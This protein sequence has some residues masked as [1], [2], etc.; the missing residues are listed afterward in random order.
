[1]QELLFLSSFAVAFSICAFLLPSYIR[2][3]RQ[4][5]IV[6]EDVHK[7][8]NPKIAECGGVILVIAYLIGLFALIGL[9]AFIPSIGRLTVEE[10][11]I[12]MLQIIGTA[13]TVLLSSFV[14]FI[15]DVYETRWRVKVL[16]PL[17]GGVP[18]AALQ[19][20][21]TTIS[22][23]F[24]ILDFAVFGLLGSIFLYCVVVPF[25]VTACANAVNMFAGLNGLE[26]GSALIIAAA[27]SFLCIVK[28]KT[29]GL[30]ILVPFLGA[31]LAF[32]LYNWYPSRVF[33]G[34]VGT[35]AMGSVIACC[36]MLA[37]LER[38]VFFMFIPHTIN[39]IM[40][41]IG[42]LKGKEPPK[43]APMN[44][45]GTLPAP[46]IWSLRSIVLKIRPMKETTALYVMLLIV[47][48]SALLGTLVYGI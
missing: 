48:A 13:A 38:A 28:G 41:F 22:T 24:G 14:G 39:A 1:L 9:L 12:M 37:Y 2:K 3:A 15:D 46:T 21:R 18:L 44:P 19:L 32:L 45:D 20:R 17:I 29:L 11:E 8:G 30:I 31:L 26:A 7:Q 40:F 10:L 16:T 33:P 34:D 43:Q 35:F 5:G 6:G 23:P 47:A 27:L 36:A 42:K 25:I 4:A